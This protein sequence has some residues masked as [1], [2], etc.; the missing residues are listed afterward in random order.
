MYFTFSISESVL[1]FTTYS[2]RRKPTQRLQSLSQSA[3]TFLQSL[4]QSAVTFLQSLT[5]RAITSPN[6]IADLSRNVALFLAVGFLAGRAGSVGH[7]HIHEEV[8]GG[9]VSPSLHHP[10]TSTP[11]IFCTRPHAPSTLH[12]RRSLF[13]GLLLIPAPSTA[14][15]LVIGH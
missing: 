6:R 10:S 7:F 15:V 13:D 3:V 4:S 9:L 2:Y 14:A 5:S 12:A 11:S 8:I 1:I